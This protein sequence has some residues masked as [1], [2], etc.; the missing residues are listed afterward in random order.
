MRVIFHASTNGREEVQDGAKVLAVHG[1]LVLEK[2]EVQ[3]CSVKEWLS[4][5]F[6]SG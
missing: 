4:R 5:R 3:L 6:G 2:Q 1:V